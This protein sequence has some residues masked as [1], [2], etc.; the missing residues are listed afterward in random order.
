MLVE[1]GEFSVTAA[2]WVFSVRFKREY[3]TTPF[4]DLPNPMYTHF[5]D[6]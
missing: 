4:K 1:V 2:K 6:T 3:Q 5:S